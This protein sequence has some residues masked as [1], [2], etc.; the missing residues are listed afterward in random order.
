MGE[1]EIKNPA[2]TKVKIAKRGETLG[3]FARSI[4]ISR[5]Y[6]SQVLSCKKKPSARIAYKIAVGIDSEVEEIFLVSDF[7]KNNPIKKGC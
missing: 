2:E 3:E 4:G 6:L 5:A 1:F 7:T